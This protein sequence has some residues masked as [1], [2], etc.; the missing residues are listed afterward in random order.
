MFLLSLLLPFDILITVSKRRVAVGSALRNC[1]GAIVD[2]RSVGR[3]PSDYIYYRSSV[4]LFPS[5]FHRHPLRDAK[6]KTNVDRYD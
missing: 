3:P 2:L 1:E 4:T 5:T 6:K